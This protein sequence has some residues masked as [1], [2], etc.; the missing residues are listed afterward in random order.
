ML[1]YDLF[2]ICDIYSFAVVFNQLIVDSI[3]PI[4]VR[5][6]PNVIVG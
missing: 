5:M 3:A 2:N 4:A 6:P 1:L